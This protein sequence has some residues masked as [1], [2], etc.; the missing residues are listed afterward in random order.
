MKAKLGILVVFLLLGSIHLVAQENEKKG[1]FYLYWGYNRSF[2]SET[3]LHFNGPDYDITFYDIKGTDRPTKF[4]WVYIN[5]TTITIP[6][7][8]FRI[9]YFLTNRFVLSFG[10]DHMKY[11]VTKHQ[12]TIISGVISP[13]ISDKYEGSFLNEPIILDPDLL[14]FEHT[15]GF[16]LVSFDVEYLQPIKLKLH[17]KI[18]IN[19]NTGIG[20]IWIATK[21]NVRVLNDGLDNDFHTA[22]YTL[23]AKTGPRIEYKNRLFFLGELK[24]GYASLPSVLIKNSEP[25][26]GDHNLSFLEYYFAVGVN[27]KFKRKREKNSTSKTR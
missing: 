19:W 9:G 10:I 20:G 13:N 22:G 5:P 8:N 24:G 17:K 16:N 11:V 1:S 26:L 25:K 23:I 6:Q 2:F 18:S 27:F 7:Y 15:D 14:I 4:G 12:E 3:N 21:T